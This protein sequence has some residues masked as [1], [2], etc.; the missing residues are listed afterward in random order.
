MKYKEVNMEVTEALIVESKLNIIELQEEEYRLDFEE[1]SI[2]SKIFDKVEELYKQKMKAL[3]AK[4]MK[5]RIT[6]IGI[7]VDL[8][9]ENDE[10]NMVCSTGNRKSNSGAYT[11][12]RENNKLKARDINYEWYTKNISFHIDTSGKSVVTFDFMLDIE[13]KQLGL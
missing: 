11:L 10:M 7:A 3:N 9:L 1:N 8:I 2:Q 12:R 5:L 13:S 6:D 4:H